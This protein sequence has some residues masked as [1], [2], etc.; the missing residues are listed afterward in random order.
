MKRKVYCV[1]L[2]K[3]TNVFRK[4]NSQCNQTPQTIIH[5]LV[6]VLSRRRSARLS[7]LLARLLLRLL[8][9]LVFLKL[10][11]RSLLCNNIVNSS[12]DGIIGG[13]QFL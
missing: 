1:P 12:S 3:K 9:F 5:N 8:L 6:N 11:I 4:Q 2:L 13:F 10:L 7:A